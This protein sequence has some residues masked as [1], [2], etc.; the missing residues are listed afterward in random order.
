MTRLLVLVGLLAMLPAGVPPKA[1]C[2]ACEARA[3]SERIPCRGN[4]VCVRDPRR[5]RGYCAP[6]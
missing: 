3:C 1:E 6:Y 4:C 2:R 5:M